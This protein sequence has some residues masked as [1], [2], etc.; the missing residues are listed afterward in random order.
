MGKHAQALMS[1]ALAVLALL[2]CELHPGQPGWKRYKNPR[3]G[4]SLAY[5]SNWISDEGV[6]KAGIRISPKR[7]LPTWLLPS[8]TVGALI[9]AHSK[10]EKA[11]SADEIFDAELRSLSQE[12]GDV[13]ILRREHI[14]FLGK[15]ALQTEISYKDPTSSTVWR[16]K[17]VRLT[18]LDELIYSFELKCSPDEVEK[19]Q[20]VYEKIIY[21]TFQFG[22]TSGKIR[23]K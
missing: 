7:D 6:N 22:S 4:F 3:W 11:A 2:A 13:S 5:P 16:E 8:I 17:A 1:G 23:A 9:N 19:L 21:E 20:P 14:N 12:A 18:T 15:P 10:N